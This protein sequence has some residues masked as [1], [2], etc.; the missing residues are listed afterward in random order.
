MQAEGNRRGPHAT[1][2]E[3][4]RIMRAASD[5]QGEPRFGPIRRSAGCEA[6][7]AGRSPRPAPRRGSLSRRRQRHERGEGHAPA[8][9]VAAVGVLVVP[10]LAVRGAPELA[11]QYHRRVLEQAVALE[12]L[13]PLRSGPDSG[14]MT[15][16]TPLNA[17]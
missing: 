7:P 13:D 11:A 2:G 8:V 5:G 14:A 16:R 17:R 6:A 10:A 4:A 15:A 9:M 3:A 12:F 1:F